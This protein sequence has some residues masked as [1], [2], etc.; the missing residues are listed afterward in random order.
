LEET[1]SN[2]SG[3]HFY[4][5]LGAVGLVSRNLFFSIIVYSG[6]VIRNTLTVLNN[7]FHRILLVID[8]L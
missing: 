3:D 8:K 4:G 2:N 6:N 1:I 5:C 7:N